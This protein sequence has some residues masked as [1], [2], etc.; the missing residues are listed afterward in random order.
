[1]P[2]PGNCTGAGTCDKGCKCAD[3]KCEGC[4]CSGCQ[5]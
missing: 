5:K 2:D 1:M 4:G 3:C